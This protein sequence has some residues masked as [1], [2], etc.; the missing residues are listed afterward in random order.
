VADDA[1]RQLYVGEENAGIWKYSAEPDGGSARTLVDGTGAGGH[2]DADVEGLAIYYANGSYGYLLAS[3]QGNNEFV[4]YERGGTNA[5]IGSFTL[6]ASGGIDAVTD[7]DGI[8]VTNFA[9]GS[10]FP[11]GLFVAQD[12]DD[13]FKLVRWDAIDAA[14]GDVLIADSSWDPRLVG[15]RPQQP[16]LQ[17]DY[18]SN[19]SV[20]AADYVVWRKAV[21]QSVTPYSRSDGNGDGRIDAA[22]Y[23][24]WRANFGRDLP[25]AAVVESAAAAIGESD[26]PRVEISEPNYVTIPAARPRSIQKRMEHEN[27]EDARQPVAQL[28]LVLER[29]D[30]RPAERQY[31][32]ARQYRSS[33]VHADAAAKDAALEPNVSV[34]SNPFAGEL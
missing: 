4:V 15:R 28:L 14:F 5:F 20:D 13:N 12:N 17:G 9:L 27:R 23:G 16:A 3:S 8:D 21:G 30:D 26:S 25:A 22:D 24:V 1:L 33:D 18:N 10:Q 7:T 6:V 19:R 2:L 29:Q 11:L 31:S 32:S 34:D